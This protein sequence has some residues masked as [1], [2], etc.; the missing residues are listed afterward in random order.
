MLYLLNFY[1]QVVKRRTSPS[2]FLQPPN[3]FTSPQQPPPPP[4]PQPTASSTPLHRHLSPPK[5]YFLKIFRATI[6][7]GCYVGLQWLLRKKITLP[8]SQICSDREKTMEWR[9]RVEIEE[10]RTEKDFNSAK[11]YEWL[12]VRIEKRQS[13]THLANR[14]YFAQRYP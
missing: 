11:Y 5:K 12:T 9:K 8:K 3:E 13:T 2:S 1:K 4:P 6:A 14:S 10:R 7:N